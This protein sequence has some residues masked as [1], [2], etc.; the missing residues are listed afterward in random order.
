MDAYTIENPPPKVKVDCSRDVPRTKQSFRDECDI[1]QVMARFE[2]TGVLD[3]GLVQRRQ[4]AFGYFGDGIDF[5]TANLALLEARAAF[6]TLSAKVRD[7]FRN[8]PARLLD[9][10]ADPENRKEAEELGLVVKAEEPQAAAT[11]SAAAGGEP[12]KAA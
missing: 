7:R 4:G 5:L 8:D 12:P 1:N 3:V 9:F 11:A 6:G 2:S 10:L